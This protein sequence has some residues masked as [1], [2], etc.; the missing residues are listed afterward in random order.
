MSHQL[1]VLSFDDSLSLYKA[2]QSRNIYIIADCIIQSKQLFQVLF[3]TVTQ[4][5]FP[6]LDYSKQGNIM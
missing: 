3:D 5:L 6:M 4:N 1:T 2:V